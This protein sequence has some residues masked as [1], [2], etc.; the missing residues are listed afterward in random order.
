MVRILIWYINNLKKLLTYYEKK[1]L[2]KIGN[3]IF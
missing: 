2:K 1:L 3:L